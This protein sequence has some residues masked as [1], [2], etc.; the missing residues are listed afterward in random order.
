MALWLF[1]IAKLI[2]SS[3]ND[4]HTIRRKA[5]EDL[6][7]HIDAHMQLRPQIDYKVCDRRGAHNG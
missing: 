1:Y 7:K 4:A 6:H 3:E 2:E 5:T